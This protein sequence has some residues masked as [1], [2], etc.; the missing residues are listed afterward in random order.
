MD[1]NTADFLD[2]KITE[3]RIKLMQDKSKEEL[4]QMLYNLQVL[5]FKKMK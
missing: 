4:D 2:E 5:I 1:E 3:I